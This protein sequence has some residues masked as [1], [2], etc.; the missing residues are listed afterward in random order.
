MSS[1]VEST[2]GPRVDRLLYGILR[3]ATH[4]EPVQL[5][6]ILDALTSAFQAEIDAAAR[7]GLDLSDP[8]AYRSHRQTLEI[9]AFLLM[10]FVQ[11]AERYIKTARD[12]DEG[13]QTTGAGKKKVRIA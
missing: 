12:N 5:S 10:W 11:A 1:W 8:T 2:A 9:Y 6:K 3:H 4:L 13:E 7:D